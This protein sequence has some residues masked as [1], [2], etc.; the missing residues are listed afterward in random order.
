M[1][2]C[3]PTIG[4]FRCRRV[5][6]QILTSVRDWRTGACVG[7][8]GWMELKEIKITKNL[9]IFE[10][11]F[12]TYNATDCCSTAAYYAPNAHP[13]HLPGASCWTVHPDSDVLASVHAVPSTRASPSS[14]ISFASSASDGA[15]NAELMFAGKRK[16]RLVHSPLVRI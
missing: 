5:G 16:A 4:S 13:I 14:A 8:M 1:V 11:S 15:G 7:G 10:T 12:R 9:E 3:W 6:P 2:K